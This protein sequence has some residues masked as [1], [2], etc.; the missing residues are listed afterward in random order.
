[1]SHSVSLSRQVTAIRIPGGDS[2]PLPA[3][4]EVTITQALGDT[5]TVAVPSL[6]GLFRIAG[7][8]ADALGKTAPTADAASTETPADLKEAAWAALKN[9][10]DPE[11]PV[12]IVDLGLV[13]TLDVTPGT[14]GKG[15]SIAAQMTLT[16][17]GCGMGP[18]IAA[19]ARAKLLGLPGVAEAT[20]VVVWDPPWGPNRISPAGREKLGMA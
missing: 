18:A 4:T 19:D 3:G 6:G 2:V 13:Y 10:Y 20:V 8:D 15:A 16:A 14:E 5:F 7:S 17:P 9:C 11:I 12:N 1:M